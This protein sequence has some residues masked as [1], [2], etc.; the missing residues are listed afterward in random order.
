MNGQTDSTTL[1]LSELIHFYYSERS[2]L[3]RCIAALF[4]IFLDSAH[5]YHSA[6]VGVLTDLVSGG[7]EKSILDQYKRTCQVTMP[8]APLPNAFD[9]Q[10]KGD[11]S[12]APSQSTM[13]MDD[14][15]LATLFADQNVQEQALLMEVLFL[16]YYENDA[17]TQERALLDDGAKST[18]S[19]AQTRFFDVYSLLHTHQFGRVQPLYPFLSARGRATV[20]WIGQLSILIGLELMAFEKLLRVYNHPIQEIKA[21]LQQHQT[22]S[23]HCTPEE[24]MDKWQANRDAAMLILHESDLTFKEHPFHDLA[25]L[26][27][28]DSAFFET[29]WNPRLQREQNGHAGQV[30]ATYYAP[31]NIAWAVALSQVYEYLE[32]VQSIQF[33]FGLHPSVSRGVD[34]SVGVSV[35]DLGRTNFELQDFQAEK[36]III[37]R[38]ENSLNGSGNP[39]QVLNSILTRVAN[40][41]RGD[42]ATGSDNGY[43]I[44]HAASNLPAF[45]EIGNE[46]LNALFQ[47]SCYSALLS[48]GSSSSLGPIF[49]LFNTIFR[50]DSALAYRFWKVD[51]EHP[52][53]R[54]PLFDTA[55]EQFPV[56]PAP[57]IDLL[58][59]LTGQTSTSS[60]GIRF[61]ASGET[62]DTRTMGDATAADTA[63]CAARVFATL[64]HMKFCSS[65]VPPD[66]HIVS[67]EQQ[68]EFNVMLTA[69]WTTPDGIVLPARTV[70]RFITTGV[71]STAQPRFMQWWH[72]YSAW[73][74]LVARLDS[75]WSAMR[76]AITLTQREWIQVVHIVQLLAKL[77]KAE[78]NLFSQLTSHLQDI[79]IGSSETAV[80]LWSASTN[81]SSLGAA[82]PQARE[83]N[84]VLT[85]MRIQAYVSLHANALLAAANASSGKAA[86]QANDASMIDSTMQDIT[87]VDSSSATMLSS[88]HLLDLLDCVSLL[89]SVASKN[90][91]G[92]WLRAFNLVMG[93]DM[94]SISSGLQ[95]NTNA[96]N[97]LANVSL[98]NTASPFQATYNYL[99]LFQRSLV[100]V[101]APLNR[102]PLFST[103]LDHLS[104][105]LLPVYQLATIQKLRL[106]DKAA[107]Y[108]FLPKQANVGNIDSD[109][110]TLP[111]N[112]AFATFME[113]FD[114]HHVLKYICESVFVQYDDWRYAIRSDRWS[115][116]S[117]LIRF[118]LLILS[119]PTAPPN[120]HK[121]PSTSGAS[122]HDISIQ[123]YLY[124]LFLTQPSM[125]LSLLRPVLFGL[126]LLDR[127]NYDRHNDDEVILLQDLLIHTFLLL[128][129][130][131]N[132]ESQHASA[133]GGGTVASFYGVLLETVAAD[134]VPSA[135]SHTNRRRGG[136]FATTPNSILQAMTEYANYTRSVELQSLAIQT[137]RLLCISGSVG[138]ANSHST[139]AHYFTPPALQNFRRTCLQLLTAHTTELSLKVQV[140]QLL[141]T[142]FE[143][144]PAMAQRFAVSSFLQQLQRLEGKENPD[145]ED[146]IDDDDSLFQ[147]LK[148]YILGAE[149]TFVGD[150]QSLL[151]IYR[152]LAA[153]WHS[154]TSIGVGHFSALQ[155]RLRTE[156]PG[157]WEK[158]TH[159]LTAEIQDA[160]EVTTRHTT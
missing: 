135:W 40:V 29:A 53:D 64:Q 46:F 79:A 93:G 18:P 147:V 49:P 88:S 81:A 16:L 143:R 47:S 138:S 61:G 78:P 159:C 20:D 7:L 83:L 144:Q 38:L 52:E 130:L 44:E 62:F 96:A 11:A 25:F 91:W 12:D 155:T 55:I 141:A 140:L 129:K 86:Q 158:L 105:V 36:Q 45:K 70:G 151:L 15:V 146:N 43:A 37:A 10:P 157:L 21:V 119:N 89:L 71:E 139:L 112:P 100:S 156:V 57:F 74:L 8:K 111:V 101:Q 99:L 69:T 116:G 137:I 103:L 142:M 54:S 17:F 85:L 3:L 152:I 48:F 26:A 133:A 68:S 51:Q 27:K 2:S 73:P 122:L 131:M 104:T 127:L 13:F 150:P 107:A 65:I 149:S 77:V 66:S 92:T 136:R 14:P 95:V 72:S 35:D 19:D 23:E 1:N 97:L 98:L 58:T 102:Y 80:T 41:A 117:Q 5:P 34:G 132:L 108:A 84:F 134:H 94:T 9:A 153:I 87:T 121:S 110:T 22:A 50:D 32:D 106:H 56:E 4:R 148:A 125:L 145:G 118:F 114:M 24:A 82:A 124:T 90:D 160:P 120:T 126:S 6:S 42:I 59:A 63:V 154:S 113:S 28:V 67:I 115:L 128:K 60:T 30:M 33:D 109:R 39:F 76:G 31:L 123:H 75:A